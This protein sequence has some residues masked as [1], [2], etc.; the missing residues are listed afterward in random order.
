M[1]RNYTQALKNFCRELELFCSNDSNRFLVS[2]F[3]MNV[4]VMNES[5]LKK[6]LQYTNVR[7]TTQRSNKN[8]SAQSQI[9]LKLDIQ[10]QINIC[11]CSKQLEWVLPLLFRQDTE[12]R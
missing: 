12:I 7:M 9:L 1:H 10:L 5:V 8:Q 3:Q 4:F 11:C 2:C 6:L